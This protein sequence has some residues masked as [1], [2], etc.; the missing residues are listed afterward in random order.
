MAGMNDTICFSDEAK[1][2]IM[3]R[4]KRA[5]GQ[6]RGIQKM[7]EEERA[8]QDLVIQLVAVKAAISQIALSVLSNQLIHCLTEDLTQGR[9]TETVTDKFMEIFKKLS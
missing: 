5:E 3:A 2:E 1:L 4:L 8:C 6:L 9:S 7:V